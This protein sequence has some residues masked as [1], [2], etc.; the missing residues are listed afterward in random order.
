MGGVILT[1]NKFLCSRS[2]LLYHPHSHF[3][4]AMSVFIPLLDGQADEDLLA[5]LRRIGPV[6]VSVLKAQQITRDTPHFILLDHSVQFNLDEIVQQL[7]QGAEK[8]IVPLTWAKEVVGVLP[9]E[10]VILM[11]DVNN[12]SAVSET[13]RNGVSGVLIKTPSL[14]TDF[15]SSISRFF[16]GRDVHV[17][18]TDT[19]T[20]PS[21]STIRELRRSGAIPVIPSSLLTLS[22]G[23]ANQVNIAEAFIAPLVSDRSDGLFP[24]VVTEDSC[25]LGLVYSSVESIKE[26]IL[27][28]NGVYQSRKHGLWRKGET[29]AT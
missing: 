2:W 24:T 3:A 12:S 11:L 16:A 6:I 14:D 19:L 13:V 26:S 29:S 9:A 22:E 10:R 15:I 8:V 5:P 28:G 21:L 25:S 20:P 4:L 1:R 7:D 17:L 23:S 18:P 27:T